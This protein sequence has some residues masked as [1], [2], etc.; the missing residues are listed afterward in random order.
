MSVVSTSNA[1]FAAWS[2]SLGG[3]G[4]RGVS[5]ADCFL[6]AMKSHVSPTHDLKRRQM[7]AKEAVG[8][9]GVARTLCSNVCCVPVRIGRHQQVEVEI[10]SCGMLCLL[11]RH[12]LL[13]Q[14]I[15]LLNMPPDCT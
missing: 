13:P 10:V 15:A 9:A 7:F 4:L 12:K 2:G 6:I 3:F 5:T 14:V 8:S 1:P 11:R